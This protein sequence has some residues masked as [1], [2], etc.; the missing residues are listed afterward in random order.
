M[1]EP[2]RSVFDHPFLGR[3]FRPFFL[4]GA[5]YSVVS[6]LIWGGFFAGHGTP[7]SFMIDP[8]SWHAHEMIFGFTM[9]IVAGFLLTAVANWTG[10]APVRQIHLAGL[11]AFWLAGRVVMN[12]DLG[13]SEIAVIVVEGAFILTLAFSLSIPLL[14][15][16]NKRNFVFLVLLSILFACDMTFFI[17]Q[18]ST[19]LYVSVMIIVAMISLIGGRIIPAF[20]VVRNK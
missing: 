2:S 9:A 12:F 3:G 20:T 18:E 14:K 16:W 7:P 19:S 6:L 13:L 15:S 10:G 5:L 8:V 1:P 17:T 4:L 11:C